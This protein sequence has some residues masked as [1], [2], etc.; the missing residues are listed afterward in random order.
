MWGKGSQVGRDFIRA[1]LMARW[2]GADISNK[3]EGEAEEGLR[4]KMSVYATLRCI[5]ASSIGSD[6]HG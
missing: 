2:R 5:Q 4:A 6:D 3:A 1:P